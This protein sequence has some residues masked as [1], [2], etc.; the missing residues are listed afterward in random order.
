ML[1]HLKDVRNV[2]PPQEWGEHC[3]DVLKG[4]ISGITPD[5]RARGV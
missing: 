1:A 3:P 5:W 4:L 2:H